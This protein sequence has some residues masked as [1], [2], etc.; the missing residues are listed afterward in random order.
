MPFMTIVDDNNMYKGIVTIKDLA[1]A[2]IDTKV[3]HLNTSY[4]NL[5]EVLHGKEINRVDEEIKGNIL[6]VA[7]RSTTFITN[8]KTITSPANVVIIA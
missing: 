2:F 6:A 5:L 1:H 7:Y 4:S 3:E 8:V